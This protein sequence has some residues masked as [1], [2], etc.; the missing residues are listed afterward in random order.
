MLSVLDHVVSAPTA[1][2][3]LAAAAGV[4]TS[5]ILYDTSWTSFGSSHEPFAPS[6]TC[7]MPKTRGDWSDVLDQATARI[8]AI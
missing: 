5:K 8:L 2:S 6:C 3:W 4:R 7:I 1:V